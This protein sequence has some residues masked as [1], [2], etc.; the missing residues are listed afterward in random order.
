MFNLHFEEICRVQSQ[1]FVFDEQLKEEIRIS[2]EK[3]LLPAYGSFIG[4]FQI[5]P[6]LAKNSD[7]YIKFGMEDIEARLNNLFQGSGG[8]NGSRK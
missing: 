1:W 2:I 7:K 5:L 8:S 4:R 3:L 6:E